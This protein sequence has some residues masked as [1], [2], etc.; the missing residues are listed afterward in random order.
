MCSSTFQ[1]YDSKRMIGRRYNDPEIQ[2]DIKRW[3]FKVIAQGDKP[4]IQ[5]RYRGETKLFSPEEIS[6]M[7]LT[8]MREIA[9]AYLGTKIKDAVVTCPAYFNDSQRQATKD[10]G[11]IAGLNVLR[12]IN[13]PTAA[14][15]LVTF[16]ALRLYEACSHCLRPRQTRQGSQCDYLRLRWWN[17]GRFPANDRKRSV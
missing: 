13:E 10:A 16:I 4:M 15:L 7:V 11:S 1:V 2:R 9:E 8:K 17:A 3:P 6:S 14:G 5:V 12:M